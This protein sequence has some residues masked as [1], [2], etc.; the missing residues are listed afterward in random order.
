MMTNPKTIWIVLVSGFLSFTLL[1]AANAQHAPA[2]YP[3]KTALYLKISGAIDSS[4]SFTGERVQATIVKSALGLPIGT[5]L[6]GIVEIARPSNA[7]AK[8]PAEIRL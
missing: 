7:D 5:T 1:P 2:F 3:K 8:T 6:V 4:N